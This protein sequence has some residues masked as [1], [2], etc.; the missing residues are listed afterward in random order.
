MKDKKYRRLQPF[1]NVPEQW[2]K[3][4]QNMPEFVQ[5]NQSS[6]KSIIVHFENKKDMNEFAKLMNQ[7]INFKTKFIWYPKMEKYSRFSKRYIDSK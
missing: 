5:E 1:L 4:W 7:K 6:Y 3:E 2:E